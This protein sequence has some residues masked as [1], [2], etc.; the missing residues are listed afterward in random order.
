MKR[1]TKYGWVDLG[2][3][4]LR[5]GKQVRFDWK[6]AAEKRSRVPFNF[7]GIEGTVIIKEKVDLQYVTID[8]PGYVSNR[9]IYVGQIANGQ[10]AACLGVRTAGFRHSVGDIVGELQII[11]RFISETSSI[12]KYYKCRC[13][14]DGYEWNLREEHLEKGVGCPVCINRKTMT[15]VNDIATTDPWLASLFA[16]P[17]EAKSYCKNSNK[18]AYFK[19]QGCGKMFRK[20]IHDVATNGLCCPVCGD[21]VSYPNKFVS[22]VIMQ[23]A[24][25]RPEDDGLQNF[26]REASFPWSQVVAVSWKP[27]GKR[28]VYDLYIPEYEIVIEN[29]GAQH[30][31]T[32]GL[33]SRDLTLEMQQE[34]D[35]AKKDVALTNGISEER[36]IQLDC[37]ESNLAYIQSS[38]MDSQLPRLLNFQTSDIN[39]AECH[40]EAQ[41][42]LVVQAW[43]LHKTGLSNKAVGDI[44][45]LDRNTI[46][47]YI[48]IGRECGVVVT[49]Q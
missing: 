29:Q 30:Y 6:A 14:R 12:H 38:I 34:N 19:C 45:R 24:K 48:S 49:T 16:F 46:S 25:S 5:K 21:G 8:I 17:E 22:N 15:G 9:R 40:R 42:S 28:M 1:I 27:E 4:P 47:R 18:F 10:L 37:R 7:Y 36:Y 32:H 43:E 44:L 41:H 3:I 35:A 11:D 23:L 2:N 33:F 20:M 39:W 31:E 13:L 26:S